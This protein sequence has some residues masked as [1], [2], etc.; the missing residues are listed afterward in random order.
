L[1]A[2]PLLRLLYGAQWDA[3]APLIRIMCFSSAIYSMSSMAR[4]F[5]V[6]TGRVKTQARLDAFTVPVRIALLVA[7]APFGLSMVA[8]AV[9]LGTAFRAW[10]TQRLLSRMGG[11]DA[12]GVVRASARG[13]LLAMISALAPAAALLTGAIDARGI[14][15]AA[16]GALLLWLSAIIVLRHPLRDEL[17]LVRLKLAAVRSH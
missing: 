9:V 5:F 12:A 7:A 6:A 13:A 1:M 3:A 14:A 2:L 4:Y 16:A 8:W 11:I 15:A 10:A 17:H